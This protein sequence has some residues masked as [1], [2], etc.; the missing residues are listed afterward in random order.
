M[1]ITLPIVTLVAVDLYTCHIYHTATIIG[2]HR[3]LTM[4]ITGLIPATT[5]AV[6]TGPTTGPTTDPTMDPTMVDITEDIMDIVKICNFN[7]YQ[8]QMKI[9]T[10]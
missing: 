10:L 8:Q 2:H 7:L 9:K 4:G 3:H 6:I 5:T 1:G